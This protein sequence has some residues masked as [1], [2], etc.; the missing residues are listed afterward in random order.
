M[1]RDANNI[2]A[3]HYN[4][5]QDSSCDQVVGAFTLIACSI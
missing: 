3:L 2:D 4:G 1:R 5:N